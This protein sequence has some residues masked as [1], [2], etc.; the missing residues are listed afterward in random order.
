MESLNAVH[1]LDSS[2]E[3]HALT[4]NSSE[5]KIIV[6][7]CCGSSLENVLTCRE[8]FDSKTPLTALFRDF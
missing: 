2:G 1:E 8:K 7:I 6:E 3:T 5:K 4:C